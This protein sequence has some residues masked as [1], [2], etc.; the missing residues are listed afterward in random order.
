MKKL[1]QI[2]KSIIAL[3][4]SMFRGNGIPKYLKK[5]LIWLETQAFAKGL[6]GDDNHDDLNEEWKAIVQTDEDQVN[7]PLVTKFKKEQ[8]LGQHLLEL[9]SKPREFFLTKW[10]AHF[11]PQLDSALL[12]VKKKHIR[13]TEK[14]AVKR[15]T[16]FNSTVRVQ[17][18]T[19]QRAGE[20]PSKPGFMDTLTIAIVFVMG[21]SAGETALSLNAIDAFF[22]ADL[23]VSLAACLTL[24]SGI[25]ISC[26]FF[27]E[28]VIKKRTLQAISSF[29]TSLVLVLIIIK[30]R[31]RVGTVEEESFKT[32]DVLAAA[33]FGMLALGMLISIRTNRNREYFKELKLKEELPE[34]I[35]VMTKEQELQTFEIET[36][37]ETFGAL[38]YAKS[39]EE[40]EELEQTLTAS[41][42][43]ATDLETKISLNSK[44]H[45][46]WEIEGLKRIQAAYQSGKEQNYN[47]QTI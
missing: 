37:K 44:Q 21:I 2:F 9:L 43:R 29:L 12:A 34:E 1:K 27:G 22:G 31:A 3:F 20:V 8:K 5:K 35:G 33:N 36:I 15:K 17:T 28:A 47:S 25:G 45:G 46:D 42:I 18:I 7:A 24:C 6:R 40:I 13:L 26:H 41:E 23:Y 32:H 11:K 10:A 30:I 16:L 38:A 19:V 4:M 39:Y 14:I